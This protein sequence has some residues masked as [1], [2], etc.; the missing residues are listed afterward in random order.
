MR[1]WKTAVVV[2][3]TIGTL[4]FGAGAFSALALALARSPSGAPDCGTPT[5]DSIPCI[6]SGHRDDAVQLSG[7]TRIGGLK[8]R[9]GNWFF[10]AKVVLTSTIS[11]PHSIPCTLT[12]GD[13]V[14]SSEAVLPPDQSNTATMTVVETFASPAY[15][16]VKCTGI[17]GESASS[18]KITAI[19]AGTLFDQPIS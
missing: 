9:A 18:L 4:T 16:I 17:S 6:E 11:S 19:R 5:V 7:A 15:A 12:A 8:V 3:T 10:V 2:G 14:D 1:S 13:N